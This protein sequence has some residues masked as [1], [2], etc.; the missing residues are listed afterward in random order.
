MLYEKLNE[1]DNAENL[2]GVTPF[3]YV[4]FGCAR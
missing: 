4:I 2:E 3:E 1:M